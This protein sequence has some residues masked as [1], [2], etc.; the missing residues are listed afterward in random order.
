MLGESEVFYIGLGLEAEKIHRQVIEGQTC[1]ESLVFRT[2][3]EI[4]KRI[5]NES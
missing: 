4:T 3:M 2:F 5:A 1:E